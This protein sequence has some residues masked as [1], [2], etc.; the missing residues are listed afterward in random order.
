MH[1]ILVAMDESDDALRALT[2]GQRLAQQVKA[3]LE[4]VSVVAAADRVEARREA[5]HAR[6]AREGGEGV[7]LEVLTHASAKDCLGE[8]AG[9]E[10]AWLCMMA[11]GRRPVPEML[12]GSVT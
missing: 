2:L 1:K 4:V 7:D 9:H 6:L 3:P 12:I 5:L 8:L 11:H 10:D